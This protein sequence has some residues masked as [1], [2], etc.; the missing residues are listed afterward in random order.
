MPWTVIPEEYGDFL[1]AIFDEWVRKDVGTFFVMNFEWAL[2]TWIGNPSPVC[3]HARQCGGSLV[4]EHN[5]DVYACDHFVY[6]EYRLGNV[7]NAPL[8]DLARKSRNTGFGN[9]KETTLPLRC[10]ECS[11]LAAC[12]GGCPKH[13]FTRTINDEPGLHYLCDG[14]KKFFHHIGK[15]MRAMTQLLENGLPVT[16]I[17]EA[18]KGPLIIKKSQ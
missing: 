6:P 14:Y 4:L 8:P 13:R 11:V 1:I 10:R 2:N 16:Y 5:G 7:Q 17:M 3:V 9:A 18:V 15:Y 12:R